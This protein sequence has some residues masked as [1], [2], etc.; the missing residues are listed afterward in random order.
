MV[1]SLSDS[2]FSS[3]IEIVNHVWD[4]DARFKPQ[5]L[6]D[7]FKEIYVGGSLGASNFAVV[8]EDEGKVRV[9][10]GKCGKADLQ[11]EYSGT[12]GESYVYELNL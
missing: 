7:V 11:Q 2:D 1:R 5:K 3:C 8:V 10:F 4:F 9:L 12:S 6:A